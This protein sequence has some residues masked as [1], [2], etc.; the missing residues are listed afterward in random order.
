MNVIAKPEWIGYTVIG[1][2]ISK[3]KVFRNLLFLNSSK[4]R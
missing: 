3:G 1:I 4:E 2:R